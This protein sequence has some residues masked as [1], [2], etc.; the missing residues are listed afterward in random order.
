VT[1]IVESALLRSVLGPGPA[2]Q[3]LRGSGDPATLV[4]QEPM[5]V[6]D[7]VEVRRRQFAAGRACARAAVR[8]LGRDLGELLP[9]PDRA[10]QWPKDLVGSITH[11][12]GF[13]GA[14]V[15]SAVR[16]RAL[17]IDAEP[18]EPLPPEVVDVVFTRT[19]RTALK[20]VPSTKTHPWDRIIFSAKESL[21]KIWSPLRQRWL[22]FEDA[23]VRLAADGTFNVRLLL[24]DTGSFP[25]AVSGRW[26]VRD[27]FL[28]TG[29]ALPRCGIAARRPPGAASSAP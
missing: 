18:A 4:G 17:G 1:V 15:A 24:A 12:E 7:A 14:A 13:A 22:G 10:P 8:H 11:C 27:G 23:E 28:A 25:R 26:A 6:A 20:D 5:V 9:G 29:L 16:W 21:F 19:E 3:E 2:V